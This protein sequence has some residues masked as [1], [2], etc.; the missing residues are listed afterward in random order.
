[1]LF[2]SVSLHKA[3]ERVLLLLRVQVLM[4]VLVMMVLVMMLV[5]MELL[6]NERL[7]ERLLM[8]LLKIVDG[9]NYLH[10]V[11]LLLPFPYGPRVR[12]LHLPTGTG[13]LESSRELVFPYLS[14][15]PLDVGT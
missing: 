11:S 6:L 12:S 13:R 2:R 10:P 15:R 4:M 1:M 8:E 7:S 9:T 3:F 5:M 14:P